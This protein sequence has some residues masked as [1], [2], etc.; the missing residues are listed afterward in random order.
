MGFALRFPN[1]SGQTER[2]QIT[3]LCGY[4]Y[5]LVG[6]LQ[7]A[8]DTLSGT[9]NHTAAQDASTPRDAAALFGEIKPLIIK[10][11]EILKAYEDR[12]SA[13]L[14]KQLRTGVLYNDENGDPVYGI[15]L[16]ETRILNEQESFGAYA[17]FTSREIVFFQDDAEVLSIRGGK[18]HFADAI[19]TS[20][21]LSDS[22]SASD[23]G[24]GRCNTGCYYQ[25]CAGTHVYV[26]FNCNFEHTGGSVQVNV[27][28]IPSE[29]CPARSVY[30][31]CATDSGMA[32][33]EVN[34]EGTVLV[35][36]L[37]A[38]SSTVKWIDG[39]IDYWL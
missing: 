16:G 21:G 20:L 22:V 13:K 7:F 27:D 34:S 25:V 2:E 9:P 33:V 14:A 19:W 5:Q 24:V 18:I 3:Q 4:L 11:T 36:P 10:S 39:Y 6:Q 17:R 32:R 15:E 23:S 1:I 26:V 12:L 30:A 8:L 38:T 28:R 31:I 37:G 29:F 35:D